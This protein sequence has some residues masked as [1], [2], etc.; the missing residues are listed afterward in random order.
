RVGL[1]HRCAGVDDDPYR[2]RA[3]AFGLAHEIAIGARI[4]FPVDAAWFVTGLVRAV[5]REFQT[6][7]ATATRVLAETIPAGAMARA[8]TQ[9]LQPRADI[10]GNQCDG[11]HRRSARI[12]N[13]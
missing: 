4:E 9:I 13:F 5:L 8:K 3:V 6:G 10:G 7:A 2:Q 12:W 11:G 1:F